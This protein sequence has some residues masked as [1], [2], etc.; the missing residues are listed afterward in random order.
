MQSESTNNWYKEWFNSPFY[1]L[2]YKNRDYKDAEFFIDSL[3]NKI[4]PSANSKILDLA[5]GKGRH[6]IYINK[7]GYQVTGIDLACDSIRFAQQYANANLDFFIHDMR[8]TFRVN[9][10]DY[11]LNMFT[12]FG[13]FENEKDTINTLQSVH[14]NLK[15]NGI[16][17]LDFFNSQKVI[18]NLIENEVKEIEGVQFLINKKIENN[19]IIKTISFTHEGKSYN[20]TEQVQ[21]LKLKDFEKFFKQSKLKIVNLY[22][23][24]SLNEYNPKNSDRLILIAQK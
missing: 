20:F 23:D 4:K 6:S 12:S 17:V 21:A 18:A 16:F 5:C 14:K 3:F 24:Y 11:V 8:H 13:Y 2:L 7:K 22:G 15:P 1:H 10:Y 9:Y 19:W